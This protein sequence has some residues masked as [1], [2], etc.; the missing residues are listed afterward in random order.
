MMKPTQNQEGDN[1]ATCLICWYWPSFLCWDL[2]LDPLMW[3]GLIEVLNVDVEHAV[4][5]LFMQDEQV[6][7]TLASHTSENPFT[8]GIRSRGVI[9]CFENLDGT[10]L[11]NSREADPK[12]AIIITDEVLRSLAIGGGLPKLLCGPR[13]GRTSCDADMNH[14]AR[15]A[16]R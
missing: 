4:E 10:R 7:E 2:L 6:I 8:D 15:C 3:P 16:I 13:V 9:G 1:L 5:L 12:L 11:R 14:S